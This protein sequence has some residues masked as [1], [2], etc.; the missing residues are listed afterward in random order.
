MWRRCYMGNVQASQHTCWIVGL[1]QMILFHVC[2]NHKPLRN[3]AVLG[4]TPR[5]GLNH[6][7]NHDHSPSF[8]GEHG[9]MFHIHIT[10]GMLATSQDH[11]HI[12]LHVLSSCER[13]LSFPSAAE[14]QRIRYF[15]TARYASYSISAFQALHC[16]GHIWN[17]SPY[18][19][20]WHP[21]HPPVTTVV[22]L[23]VSR[24][25]GKEQCYIELLLKT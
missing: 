2:F 4:R 22:C 11:V 8:Q 3:P 16:V 15:L 7:L 20:F 24:K 21:I 13:V 19:S 14:L 5:P 6:F 10:V 9:S 1:C 18:A 17:I 12:L 25:K 23:L